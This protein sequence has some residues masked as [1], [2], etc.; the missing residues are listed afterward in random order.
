MGWKRDDFIMMSPGTGLSELRRLLSSD[1]DAGLGPY[2][3][4]FRRHVSGLLPETARVAVYYI[5]DSR[6]PRL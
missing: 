1:Q 5:S 3:A 4:V 2:G 6:P